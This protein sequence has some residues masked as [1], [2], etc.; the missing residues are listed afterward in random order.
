MLNELQATPRQRHVLA[1]GARR[2]AKMS[3]RGQTFRPG[4]PGGTRCQRSIARVDTE[5]SGRCRAARARPAPAGPGPAGRCAPPVQTDSNPA[6]SAA[7]ATRTAVTGSLHHPM[8]MAKRP[9]FITRT[10]PTLRCAR[11]SAS[12]T[13]PRRGTPRCARCRPAGRGGRAPCVQPSASRRR[14][15]RPTRWLRSPR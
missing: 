12:R 1:G 5:I 10:R 9:N 8:L 7:C 11:R 3:T 2:R 6:A 4:G 15:R 13:G 14:S